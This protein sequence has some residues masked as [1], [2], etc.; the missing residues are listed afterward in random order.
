MAER[1]RQLGS[2]LTLLVMAA[3]PGEV[4][5]V[6][7]ESGLGCERERAAVKVRQLEVTAAGE[8]GFGDVGMGHAD[9]EVVI[10]GPETGVEEI[11]GG[12]GQGE[13]VIGGIGASLGVGM[14][15]RGLK[16]DIGRLGRDEA[17]T[18]QCAGEAVARDDRD[19]ETGVPAPAKLGLIGG[20]V[21]ADLG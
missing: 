20:L 2:S 6:G 21:L 8:D 12:R 7:T 5:A 1:V 19:L 18:G 11:M 4:D 17:V 14:D 10:D 3:M 9:A 16:G 15:M 13:A